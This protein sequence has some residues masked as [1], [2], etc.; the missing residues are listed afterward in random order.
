MPLTQLPPR[1]PD[2]ECGTTL[3]HTAVGVYAPVRLHIVPPPSS[4]Q[5]YQTGGPMG[6]GAEQ[7]VNRRTRTAVRG[8]DS[9]LLP[10]SPNL[11][12]CFKGLA[13]VVLTHPPESDNEWL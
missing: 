1:G 5:I 12:F 9:L 7:G 2:A 6:Y 8:Q 11:L 10:H 3:V 13:F 4:L